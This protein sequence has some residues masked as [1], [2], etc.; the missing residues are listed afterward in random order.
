MAKR[1]NGIVISPEERKI[2][3]KMRQ[4]YTLKSLKTGKKEFTN[5]EWTGFEFYIDPEMFMNLRSKNLV[6]DDPQGMSRGD[7]LRYHRITKKA[8]DLLTPKEE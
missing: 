8:K 5:I 7:N 4:G 6:T 2:L 3:L 1:K